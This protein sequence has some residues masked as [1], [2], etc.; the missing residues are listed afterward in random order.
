M[1]ETTLEDQDRQDTVISREAGILPTATT[2]QCF[3]TD[4]GT[5]M[6][7]SISMDSILMGYFMATTGTIA[8]E[9]ASEEEGCLAATTICLPVQRV[10]VFAPSVRLDLSDPSDP[11]L[12][13]KGL[14]RS[15]TA[16]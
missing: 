13:G 6:D 7:T 15:L 11:G 10:M 12:S 1:T 16:S 4:M 9:T 5:A 3:M 8:T 14:A 2:G